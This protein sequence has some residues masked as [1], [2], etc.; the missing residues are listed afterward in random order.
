MNFRWGARQDLL[1]PYDGD[2]A[3]TVFLS[4]CFLCV[5]FY[6]VFRKKKDGVVN[7]LAV[8]DGCCCFY[9]DVCFLCCFAVSNLARGMRIGPAFEQAAHAMNLN[10]LHCFCTINV[11][12]V[13]RDSM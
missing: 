2:V 1:G 3:T 13:Y 10:F 12:C 11:S 6:F 4:L 8:G 5:F 7:S 9:V